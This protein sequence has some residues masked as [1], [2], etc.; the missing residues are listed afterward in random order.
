MCDV[1]RTMGVSDDGAESVG[2]S[3]YV[4][5]RDAKDLG[6]KQFEKRCSVE[7]TTLGR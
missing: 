1:M 5:L 4:G 2:V 6:H 7:E 3:D